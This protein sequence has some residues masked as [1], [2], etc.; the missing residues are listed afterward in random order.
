[1]A[2]ILNKHYTTHISTLIKCI[3]HTDGGVLELGAG[4]ASTPLLHWLCQENQRPLYTFESNNYFFKYARLFQSRN[5]RIRYVDWDTFEIGGHWSVAFIDQ[6]SKYRARSIIYLK[7]RVDYFVL[8]D[9]DG[10]GVSR[11]HDVL[12]MFKNR[13]DWKACRP[14]TTVVSDKDLSWL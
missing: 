1:M 13:Y 6:P 11:Y 12:A 7:D 2:N 10:A 5:H 8:H 4:P 14:W 9:T 3:Q